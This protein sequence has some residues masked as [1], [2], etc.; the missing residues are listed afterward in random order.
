M[1]IRASEE[2]G[3]SRRRICTVIQISERRI[4]HWE[5]RMDRLRDQKPG[6]S[7]APHRLLPKEKRAI[8]IMGKDERYV[9][10][11]HRVLAAKGTDLD[12]FHASASAVYRVLR[13]AGLTTDRSGRAA[14]NGKRTKPD[15]P[16]LSGRNQ[17]WCWDI[18]Y[19]K[20]TLKRTFLYLYVL[21]DEYS[22]KVIAWRISH[23]LSHQEG[24]ELIEDGLIN[25]NLSGK[26]ST[27]PD[28]YNDRGVQMKAKPFMAMLQDLGMAQKFT[29]PRTPNDNPFIESH[30]SI[31]KGHTE[32]P[33]EFPLDDIFALTY[34]TGY[35]QWYNNDRLHGGIDFVTPVQKH[36]GEDRAIL[37]QRKL[38]K[39]QARKNR[40]KQNTLFLPVAFGTPLVIKECNR[41]L[42]SAE[43]GL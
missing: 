24:K 13:E 40:I 43:N 5:K 12:L 37:A 1:V 10:D 36:T 6:W 15:R 32:Y 18:S 29:R 21:L 8:L 42:M 9:D 25:E 35:F 26:G 33:E 17:R 31:V 34:F 23:N 28:V 38:K 7:C 14:R 19:L 11:S 27:M 2:Q 16:E 39:I 4:R 20:T 30:F 3:L 41:I 22:R